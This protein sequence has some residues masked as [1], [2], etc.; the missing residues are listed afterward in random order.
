MLGTKGKTREEMVETLLLA[1]GESRVHPEAE[2]GGVQ[3][4]VLTIALAAMVRV[5]EDVVRGRLSVREAE[6]ILTARWSR[7]GECGATMSA[8]MLLVRA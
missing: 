1:A 5:G 3:R 8:R 7:T 4:V 6:L 2:R